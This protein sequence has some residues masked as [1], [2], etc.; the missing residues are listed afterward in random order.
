MAIAQYLR[1]TEVALVALKNVMNLHIEKNKKQHIDSKVNAQDTRSKTLHA[2]AKAGCGSV[3]KYRGAAAKRQ[4]DAGRG[5][6][7]R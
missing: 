6:I 7:G 2:E 1:A 4:A 5:Y 3:Q